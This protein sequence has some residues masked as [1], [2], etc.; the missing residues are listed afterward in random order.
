MSGKAWS[1]GARVGSWRTGNPSL[2]PDYVPV[3]IT[4]CSNGPLQE[5]RPAQERSLPQLQANARSF[6]LQQM[7]TSS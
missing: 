5:Q 2:S 6:S 1:L 3:G 4:D 7:H